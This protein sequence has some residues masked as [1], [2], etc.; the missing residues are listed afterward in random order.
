MSLYLN[1]STTFIIS[2]YVTLDNSLSNGKLMIL[3]WLYV[4]CRELFLSL[5]FF[6][7]TTFLLFHFA[8]FPF[9][10]ECNVMEMIM[11][12]I[13][14]AFS[15]ASHSLYF[16]FLPL[17]LTIAISITLLPLNYNYSFSHTL[18]STII[19]HHLIY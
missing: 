17:F 2:T 5:N 19:S 7:F 12:F 14:A 3:A 16:L 1:Y 11:N 8:Y 10:S 6:S 18:S 9:W 13:S 15:L 4:K